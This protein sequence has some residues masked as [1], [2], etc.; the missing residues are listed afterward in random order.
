MVFPHHPV[1]SQLLPVGLL[2]GRR[3]WVLWI[4]TGRPRPELA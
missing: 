4:C 3:L 1:L 2:G